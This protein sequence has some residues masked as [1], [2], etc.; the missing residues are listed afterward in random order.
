MADADRSIVKVPNL[1]V[2]FVALCVE[3]L[4]LYGSNP[5]QP[6]RFNRQKMNDIETKIAKR[7]WHRFGNPSVVEWE[8]ETHKAEYQD[9]AVEVLHLATRG[10][11][12]PS[13]CQ[14]CGRTD[15]EYSHTAWIC[16]D[17]WHA[18]DHLRRQR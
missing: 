9:A 17:P 1:L 13:H 18:D 3:V 12:V 2:H 7:L 4:E 8:D 16:K 11:G 10:E 6:T 14:S 15:K 5:L